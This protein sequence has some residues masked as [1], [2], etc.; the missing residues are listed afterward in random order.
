MPWWQIIAILIAVGLV[1]GLV[2][3]VLSSVLGFS[4]S[5]TAPA[6]GASLGVFGAALINRRRNA[7]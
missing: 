2:V 1:V 3:G 4:G 6:I 5:W 7:E